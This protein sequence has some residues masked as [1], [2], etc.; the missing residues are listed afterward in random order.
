[1]APQK[2][3]RTERRPKKNTNGSSAGRR[4]VIAAAATAATRLHTRLEEWVLNREFGCEERAKLT[5]QIERQLL[6]SESHVDQLNFEKI[7][8]GALEF[9]MNAYDRDFFN[10]MCREYLQQTNVPLTFR[11]SNRMTN[12]GGTTTRKSTRPDPGKPQEHRFEIAL[13]TRLLF[14]SFSEQNDSQTLQVSGVTCHNRTE[15]MQR[16]FEHELIHLIEW[17]LWNDS[18]CAK[19]QFC[20]IAKRFFGHQ[21]STHRLITP[22]ENAA[23]Q[24]NIRPGDQVSFLY[25][26]RRR[27]GTVNRINRRATILVA[28]RDGRRYNDGKKYTKYYVPLSQLKR[29]G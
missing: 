4:N 22:R 20:G 16:I 19:K 14:Q 3:S 8:T 11:L 15:A 29:V 9:L 13:S 1:M 6:E 28:T 21:A 5:S 2:Q 18:S 27:R 7:H 10:G 25:E 24:Y 23:R 12:A 26:G 17:L